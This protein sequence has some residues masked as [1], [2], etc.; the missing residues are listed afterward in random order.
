MGGSSETGYGK[1]VLAAVKLSDV[2]LGQ[3]D[4]LDD[5]ERQMA[6]RFASTMQRGRFLAGRMALRLHVA[7]VAGVDPRSL[8]ADYVCRNCQGA[9]RVHGAP[10]Y[11]AGADGLWIRASLSRSGDWCLLA[12]VVN[13]QVRGVGVDLESFASANFEG[14][15]V[16]AMTARE[17]EY[18][19][20]VPAPQRALCQ[21]VL[22]TRKEAVLKALGSGLALDPSLVDVAG[23]VPLLPGWMSGPGRWVVEDVELGLLG[24]ADDGVAAMAVVMNG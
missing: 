2:D 14:F 9:D 23:G 3:L 19:Q 6:G 17:R 16:V 7:E 21:T 18:L 13:E 22:W 11:R 24:V 4:F 8:H 5:A 1:P 10:R 15:E 20:E 12:A